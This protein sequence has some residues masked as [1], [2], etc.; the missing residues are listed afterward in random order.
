MRDITNLMI[1]LLI[2]SSFSLTYYSYA[3]DVP[4]TGVVPGMGTYS[5]S[6]QSIRERKFE[7][8]IEQ[9]TDFSCGAASLASLLKYAYDRQ[10]INEQE[11]L[12]GMLEHADLTLVQEQGFSLLNMKR[13]LQSQGLRGRGYKVGEAEMLLLKIPAIVLLNDGGYSHFVVF[14]RHDRGE[15]YLGDPALGNR[16]MTMDEFTQKWNGVVFVVIGQEYRRDNPLLHPRAKLTFKA[17]DPLSPMTDAE[18]LEF[19]FSYSD[20]L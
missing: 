12:I 10:D 20:M 6:I 4:L 19:G 15:V 11:V 16:I 3:A 2:M 5:K 1:A 13:Y 14:R 9:K 17:L 7:H 8:V 18:L